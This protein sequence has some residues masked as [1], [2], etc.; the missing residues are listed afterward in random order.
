MHG[1]YSSR[2]EHQIICIRNIQEHIYVVRYLNA[3][4]E[5]KH[6]KIWYDEGSSQFQNMKESV[7]KCCVSI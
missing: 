3:V 7:F 5:T 2:V 6:N 4:R 1:F